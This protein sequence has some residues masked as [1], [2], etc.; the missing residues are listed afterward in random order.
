M[1]HRHLIALTS[2]ALVSVIGVGVSVAIAQTPPAQTF[3]PGP[4]QPIARIDPNRQV[5]I[6]LVNESGLTIE[7]SFS[8]SQ[9]TSQML[10]ASTTA[11]LIDIA[12]PTFLLINAANPD[13]TVWY[14]ISV[15]EGSNTVD[16]RVQ[17]IEVESA[18][19]TTLNV[20]ETGGI[21]AY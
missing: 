15:D 18:G 16:V 14:D 6:R 21:Y 12:V 3:Q 17:R 10:S 1:N 7:Y 11:T 13:D 8:E 19:Y 4:W 9:G 2:A 20:H 5:D